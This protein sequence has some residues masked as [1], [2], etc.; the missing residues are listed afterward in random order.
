MVESDQGG[1]VSKIDLD[2]YQHFKHG[3]ANTIHS[4]QGMTVENAYI[5][6]SENM[7]ANLTYVALTR[8]KGNVELNYSATAFNQDEK[9]W[10]RNSEGKYQEKEL[11][12]FD[13]LK[14]TLGRT[15]VK[16]FTT[17]YSVV[18]AKDE[19]IK[20]YIRDHRNSLD[21][22]RELYNL[23]STFKAITTP[24]K[25]FSEKEIIE[26]V[27][28]SLRSKALLGDEIVRF[29]GKMNIAKGEQLQLDQEL[30]LKT[31]FFKKEHFEKDTPLQVIDAYKVK[32]QAMMK[33]RIKAE[34]YEVP[35]D[36]LNIRY[37]DKYLTEYKKDTSA[38][39]DSR[40]KAEM[41]SK[42]NQ[43]LQQQKQSQP[44]KNLNAPNSEIKHSPSIKNSHKMKF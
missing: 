42:F 21:D 44:S 20:N 10:V 43:Q 17:D 27:R 22:Q 28:N 32:D 5:L 12:P 36:R 23:N 29:K 8:H 33:V 15:E 40:H 26:E 2:S 1:K 41:V 13:N 24:D 30:T 31:G 11:T 16:S 37:S 6:A 18:Q 38:R 3:Y 4:S 9:T 34:E 35:F 7:N 19:L 14:R 25:H 39:F